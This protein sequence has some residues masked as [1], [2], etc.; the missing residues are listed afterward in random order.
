MSES[1]PPTGVTTQDL[2]DSGSFTQVAAI[3]GVEFQD[4]FSGRVAGWFRNF[5]KALK[6]C[7]VY[8][9]NNEMHQKFLENAHQGLTSLL[10]DLPELSLSVREDRILY[11]KDPVYINSDRQEGL[12]FIL[13]RNAFRRLTLV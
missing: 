4:P 10:A 13:Y 1:Y 2:T 3:K 5:A 7:R 11:G 8:A 6:A 9:E 12:F